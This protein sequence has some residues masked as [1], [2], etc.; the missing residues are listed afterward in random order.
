MRSKW[1]GA[2]ADKLEVFV[3]ESGLSYKTSNKSYIFTCPLCRKPDKLYI[4]RYDG[5]FICWVCAE[6]SSFKGAPEFAFVELTNLPLKEIRKALYGDN[7][8]YDVSRYLDVRFDDFSDEEGYEDTIALPELDRP[9]HHL[10][11]DHRSSELG[12]NYL[13]GRG[14]PADIA[15]QYNIRY[16]P[17]N[18]AVVFPV[19]MGDSLVGWQYRTIDP[20]EVVKGGQTFTR[21]KIWSSDDMPREHVV[22]FANRLTEDHAVLCEGPFDALKAHLVGGNVASMGKTLNYQ[23]VDLL[24]R[25]GVRKLYLAQDPDAAYD[26]DSIL[27][28]FGDVPCYRVEIPSPYEDLGQMPMEY[29]RDTILSSQLL[30][31]NR[32]HLYF[33][34]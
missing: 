32:L 11:L 13:E 27:E 23:Q 7:Q 34:S 4:R 17:E 6:T 1:K 18:R 29:A 28:K 16:S 2:D 31:M 22:M 25:A 26:V 10:P 3:K 19:E 21:L 33:P 24:L 20:T 15:M 30:K 12:V 8:S 9:Y 5:R 14:V